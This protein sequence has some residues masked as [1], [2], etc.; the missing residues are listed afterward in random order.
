[1]KPFINIGR[2]KFLRDS[3]LG[4]GATPLMARA[5]VPGSATQ[6]SVQGAASS[7]A[8]G[9]K[10]LAKFGSTTSV[11][12]I[13]DP[14]AGFQEQ[15]ASR[16]LA[17][18]LRNLGLAREP[19]QA[20]VGE[21][22]IPS[23]GLTFFLMVDR[24]KFKHPEAYEIS[25]Q[26]A[27]G[28]P[29][30]VRLTSATPQ[31]VLYSVFDFLE[32][33]GAFFGLD[34]EVY[35]L[36]VAK[37]LALPPASQP[38]A[39][40]PRF[41]VRGLNPWPNFLN[42][43]AVFNRE[44]FRT[45]LEAM[46]RMR[47][48]TLGM[49]VFTQGLPLDD[50]YLPFE[51]C[52]VGH[53]VSQDTTTTNRWN[54]LP[55]RTST[56]G[57]GAPDL[58]DGEVFGSEA[59]TQARS[60]WEAAELAQQLWRESFKYAQQLGVRVGLG[61]EPYQ[62]PDEIFSAAPPEARYVAK[63]PKIPGPRIDPDSVTAR[64]ILET[65]LGRLLEA[66]PTVDYVWLWEGEDLNWASQKDNVPFSTTP[67][68]QAHG[69]LRRHAP[70]KRIV[71]S[72]WGGVARHF[73][74]FHKELPGDIIFSSLNDNLGW[75]PVSE[76][77]GKLEDRERWAIP[78]LEDDPAMW[79]PQFH[80]Y[81]NH[82]YMDQAEQ[83][84]CAGV[85]GLHWRHRIMDADAA[86]NA[87]YSWDKTLQPDGFFKAF[88]AV[89]ARAPRAASL[90]KVLDDTDRD[91]LILCSFTGKIKDGHHQINEY[92]GDYS[93]A[94]QFW[95]GYAPPAEVM[96][97]QAKVA[98]NLRQL[99]AAASSPAERE[100]LNYLA[101]FVEFLAPYSESWV[102]SSRLHNLLQQ[103]LELKKEGKA[104]EARQKVLAEGVPLWLKLAPLVRDA[105]LDFQ[106]IVSNRND[107]GALASLHNKYERL[108]LF[109]LR[110]SMKEFLG[111][112]PPETEELLGEVRKPEANAAQRLFIP[113]R[114]TLLR[115]GERVRVFAVAPGHG[116][117]VR[118]TLNLRTGG[119]EKWSQRPM[120]LVDRRTF[121]GELA[122]DTSATSLMDYYAEAQFMAGG[123]KSAVTAPLEA[124]ARF[125]TVTLV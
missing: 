14:H 45:Y 2:R 50:S 28:K 71:L 117:K 76:V 9:L 70:E 47:F 18:G 97:S 100:R 43:I 90:A 36:E 37:T 56:F 46:M 61:F 22:Q 62:I 107:I 116:E 108:A 35:P 19:V 65:R 29:A 3:A 26:A 17:R 89:Q 75:D 41:K 44:D 30:Q 99:T 106:E 52:N 119:S 5:A 23:S 92:S 86:L 20:A 113:T 121:T 69:F 11:W 98:A 82:E 24:S 8:D 51:Y 79:L 34:G 120:K 7:N 125:Y 55:Q 73:A 109:R 122:C 88:A 66:Y 27:A 114:P 68:K 94:F 103:A 96:K 95:L 58:Y 59:T 115:A 85:L 60:C 110:M 93:E 39:G 15:W 12:I 105:L 21:G 6:G 111:E 124:P 77:Y 101:R 1:M 32:R 112:L 4:L 33:Q 53:Q 91:R 54:Y 10:M 104:D 64:D 78:W 81:R 72:G 40:Q 118:V 67:F 49:H 74:Y 63:D 84:G 42:S 48:N 16:E 13:R 57:M 25:Y 38:W 31:A 87:R 80:V 123:V 83:F 102:L